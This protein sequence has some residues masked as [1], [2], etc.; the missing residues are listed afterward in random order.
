MYVLVAQGIAR[1]T[2]NPEVVGS[3]PTEDAKQNIFVRSVITV[4]IHL[5]SFSVFKIDQMSIFDHIKHV[6]EM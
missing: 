6:K 2:S 1:R 5:A 3:N 4:Y